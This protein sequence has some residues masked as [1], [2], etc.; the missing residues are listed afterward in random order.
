MPLHSKV[1]SFCEMLLTAVK[2]VLQKIS[3]SQFEHINEILRVN[4]RDY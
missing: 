3:V 4:A 2:K 1:Y